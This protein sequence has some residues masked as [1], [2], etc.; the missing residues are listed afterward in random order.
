MPLPYDATLKDLAQVSPR[1]LLSAFDTVP[2]VP[3]SLLNIDLSTVTTA[4]DVVFGLGAPL[5]EIVHL[6]FQ[7]SA[8]ATKHADIPVYNALLHRQ[9]GVPVHSIVI[10]LRPEAAHANLHG[11]VAYAPRPDR[12]KMDF[13]Y[14]VVRLWER[15]ASELLE[16]DVGAWPLAVLGKLDPG[17]SLESGMAVVVER[18]IERLDRELPKEPA[19]R[20]LTASYV[21][22]GLRVEKKVAIDFFKG[23]QAMRES[24]TYMAIVEEGVEKGVE[25]GQIK[26]VRKLIKQLGREMLGPPSKK[27]IAVIAG[28][29]DL[30]RLEALHK[31]VVKVKTWKELLAE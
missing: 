11:R 7:S 28:I 17:E 6:D 1:R 15:A 29:H 23:A 10:L 27:V 21:L 25:K 30:D 26:E 19:R 24:V 9:F 3:V 14:E 12:G 4:A 18:L 13:A 2:P 20:L 8:S 31:R 5:R 22:S 16:G